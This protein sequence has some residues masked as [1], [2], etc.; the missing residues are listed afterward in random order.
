MLSEFLRCVEL[1][2]KWHLFGREHNKHTR[3][4]SLIYVSE[5]C[6][7]KTIWKGSSCVLSRDIWGRGVIDVLPQH[8][9]QVGSLSAYFCIKNRRV[10]CI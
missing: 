6:G 3:I 2:M 5:Y 9:C 4:P 1:H 7:R 10:P 8:H